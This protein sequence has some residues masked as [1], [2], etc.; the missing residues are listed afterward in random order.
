MTEKTIDQLEE[1]LR[2]AKAETNRWKNRYDPKDNVQRISFLSAGG[3][4][5]GAYRV[6]SLETGDWI[7]SVQYHM[8]YNNVV[9]GVMGEEAAKLFSKFVQDLAKD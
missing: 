1:E 3:L 5:V 6:R 8:T 4:Q 2:L 9:L 7:D